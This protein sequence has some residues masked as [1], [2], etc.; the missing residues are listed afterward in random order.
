MEIIAR[1]LQRAKTKPQFGVADNPRLAPEPDQTG[2]ERNRSF[3]QD[4]VASLSP[5][6][7]LAN[8]IV[9]QD[10][11]HR[12]TRSY[13]VLRNQLVTVN[14]GR[15]PGVLAVTAPTAGCGAT[16]AAIN[17][18]FSFARAREADVLLIDANPR[19]QTIA[20]A[21]GLGGVPGADAAH[22]QP[23]LQRVGIDGL[24]IQLFTPLRLTGT[25]PSRADSSQLARQIDTVRRSLNP[26][27]TIL[28][29]PP[30]LASDEAASLA[31]VADTVLLV[32]AVG[33]SRVSELEM[34]KSYLDPRSNLQV[35]LNKCRRHGL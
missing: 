15:T 1:A 17:L 5:S 30:L 7:L 21:L 12:I 25:A 29:L 32:L 31:A 11:N 28:D 34:C 19:G 23:G 4:Q 24:Q 8:R 22:Q 27:I 20:E 9:A 13:D 14:D 3:G 6:V 18:A 2:V 10:T 16:T 33:Q 26:S 35:M